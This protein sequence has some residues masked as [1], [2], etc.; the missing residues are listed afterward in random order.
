MEDEGGVRREI[1]SSAPYSPSSNGVAKR[2]VGV[3]RNGTQ[4][5]LQDLGLQ[6]RFWGATFMYLHQQRENAI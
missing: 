5:M 4:A 6:Q 2:L 1:I 3:A